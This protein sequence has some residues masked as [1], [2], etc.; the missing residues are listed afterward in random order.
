MFFRF[1]KEKDRRNRHVIANFLFH[2]G[3]IIYI[4]E[5]IGEN[6][7]GSDDGDEWKTNTHTVHWLCGCF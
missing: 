5:R 1:F 3:D 6:L 4:E 2:C 7:Q